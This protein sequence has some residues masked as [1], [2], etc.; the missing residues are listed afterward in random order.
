VK[1][2][3]RTRPGVIEYDLINR[4]MHIFLSEKSVD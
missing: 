1:T 2:C 4:N 3:R